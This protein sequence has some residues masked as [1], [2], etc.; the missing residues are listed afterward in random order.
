MRLGKWLLLPL[1]FAAAMAGE[2]G[3]HWQQLTDPVAA[4][5]SKDGLDGVKSYLDEIG[6]TTAL[7]V[8]HGVIVAAYGDVTRPSNLHSARKSLI[9]ALVGVAVADGKI[10][11]DDTLAA[12]AI[13]DRSPAL[14]EAEKQASVRELLQARSGVY[15][16]AAYETNGMKD[17]RPERGSHPHGTF[18]YYNNWDFNVLGAITE[19]GEGRSVFD[20]FAARI[21]E[22]IG[23]E[24]FSPRRCRYVRSPIPIIPPIC[25]TSAPAISPASPCSICAVGA[26]TACRWC[27]KIGSGPAPSLIPTPRPA[28]TACCGGPAT[29]LPAN[30]AKLPFPKTV[31]GPRAISASMP[32]WCRRAISSS[33]TWSTNA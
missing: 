4:G 15:H 21:A 24:D 8:Q 5:W 28:A 10:H 20:S 1:A 2:P 27:R 11:L 19:H 3:G 23:M 6:S 31:S 25:S 33:S 22:P 7:I 29:T 18:W 17:K 12:L 13:D 32:W 9:N 14:S 16:H 26:G 30:V